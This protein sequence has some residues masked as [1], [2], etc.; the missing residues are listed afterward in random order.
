[1][2]VSTHLTQ[3][4]NKQSGTEYFI[5]ALKLLCNLE[6]FPVL[7][8]PKNHNKCY[9][10][11]QTQEAEEKEEHN[12]GAWVYRLRLLLSTAM[13]EGNNAPSKRHD[14]PLFSLLSSSNC[15]NV[16]GKRYEWKSY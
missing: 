4:S 11:L 6:N 15:F 1:M 12:E 7:V 2:N 9:E 8:S 14:F 16:D 10:Q 3:N 5:V 13:K